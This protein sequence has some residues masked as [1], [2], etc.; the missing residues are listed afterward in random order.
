MQGSRI[1]RGAGLAALATVVGLVVGLLGASP[2][3][4]NVQLGSIAPG[5]SET[6]AIS[7]EVEVT[8]TLGE[9]TLVT[10]ADVQ[11][12]AR[13]TQDQKVELTAE[14]ARRAIYSNHY[15]QFTTGGAYTVTQNGTFYYNG[16]R[17]WVTVTY[18][19]YTGS[20]SCFIN[21]AVGVTISNIVCSESGTTSRRDMYMGW[22]VTIG[23]IQ[24]GYSMTAKLYPDGTIS[25]FG[26]TVG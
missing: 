3:S 2:A 17:V 21:Y 24:Y 10:A 7:A 26:A 18:S 8:T 12:D 11:A 20:H 22:T 16:T 14:L 15:S 4:A 19:G 6:T 23:G 13:L 25:G 5:E 9:P 1:T